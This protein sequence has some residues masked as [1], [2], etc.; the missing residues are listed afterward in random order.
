MENSTEIG[1]GLDEPAAELLATSRAL[2][3]V[4]A[5][6]LTELTEQV[7]IQQF[8]ILVLLTEEGPSRIGDIADDIGVSSSTATRSV[9]RILRQGWIEK[10]PDMGSQRET[11]VA[12]TA[13]GASL[14]DGVMA[15][16]LVQIRAILT[17]MTDEQR[18]SALQG[19]ALFNRA[20]SRSARL[21]ARGLSHE[22]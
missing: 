18:A 9:A 5:R 17:D 14:V 22:R 13:S 7:T 10:R 4:T 6:S 19:F 2:F 15:S 11:Y 21:R 12:L 3:A 16:R 8:R 20:A 1:Q